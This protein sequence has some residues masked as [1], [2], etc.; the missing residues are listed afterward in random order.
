MKKRIVTA[1]LA[2]ALTLSLSACAGINESGVNSLVSN[3][4]EAS[5]NENSDTPAGDDR[6]ELYDKYQKGSMEFDFTKSGQ[7]EIEYTG[8]PINIEFSGNASN[9]EEDIT[10]G[11]MAFIGGVPQ[12]ISVNGSEEAETVNVEFPKGKITDVSVTIDPRITKELQDKENLDLQIM[13]I[14]N[15]DYVPQG[16]YVGFDFGNINNGS[17]LLN[18]T[19]KM[20]TK[21]EIYELNGKTEFENIPASDSTLKAYSLKRGGETG[22][23]AT[24]KMFSVNNETEHFILDSNKQVCDVLFDG[25]D[26]DTYN[27]FFYVNHKRVQVNGADFATVSA[28]AGYVPKLTATLENVNN[29]DIIY[30][31]AVP[32]TDDYEKARIAKS[33]SKLSFSPDDEIITDPATD[34]PTDTSTDVPESRTDPEIVSDGELYGN[35]VVGYIDDDMKYLLLYKRTQVPSADD[36]EEFNELYIYSVYNKSAGKITGSFEIEALPYYISCCDGQLTFI[37]EKPNEDNS[38]VAERYAVT[39]NENL[40]EVCRL[41]NLSVDENMYYFSAVYSKELDKYFVCHKSENDTGYLISRFDKGGKEEKQIFADKDYD[42]CSNILI[43]DNRL[44]LGKYHY[45]PSKPYSSMQVIDFDGNTVT[46][47]IRQSDEYYAL[48]VQKVGNYYC[49]LSTRTGYDPKSQQSPEDTLYLYNGKTGKTVEFKP[50]EAIEMSCIRLTPDGTKAVTITRDNV[51]NEDETDVLYKNLVVRIYDIES[52]KKINEIKHDNA[53][54]VMGRNIQAFDDRVI[55]Y[56]ATNTDS[57]L[58]QFKYD[59]QVG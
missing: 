3:P 26:F 58:Y 38:A 13:T 41:K 20:S 16:K 4:F 43:S 45:S 12:S 36:P 42:Y 9:N 19:L 56:E 24:L 25:T 11:F 52:G 7:A 10:L 59:E 33:K 29:H 32:T 51:M 17:S 57:I 1:L 46:D 18:K 34:L 40:E 49:P 21:A 30:A 31:I 28:K 35:N 8:E 39:Y 27:V 50:E 15:I 2:A 53:G 55:V 14:F 22:S 37:E 6:Y 5:G 48:T 23:G 54:G 47:D 44:V